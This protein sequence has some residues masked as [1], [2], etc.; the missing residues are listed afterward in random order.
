[1][2]DP[3]PQTS[4][5]ID[6]PSRAAVAA[7]YGAGALVVLGL[8]LALLAI[9]IQVSDSFG[10]MLKLATPWPQFVVQEFTQPSYLRPLL[11]IPLKA[12]HDLSGGHYYAWFRGV[13]VVQVVVLVL[14]FLHLLRP[15]TWRDAAAVPLGLA[16]LVGHHAFTGTVN[17]AF[18]INTFLTVVICCLAAAALALGKERRVNAA[19][20]VVLF[21]Y[22]ALTVESGLLVFVVFVVA[23]ATGARGVPRAGLVALAVALVGYFA[24]RFAVLDVGTPSLSERSSGF[25]FSV[26]DPPELAQ[27]FSDRRLFFYAYNVVAS[28]LSVVFGEPRGGVFRL[29][30]GFRLGAPYPSLLATAVASTAASAL[31]AVFAWHRRSLWRAWQFTHDDRLVLLF[32]VLLPANAAISFP[33]TKD[34]I[35]SPAGAF[36]ALAACVA[37]R[38]LLVPPAGA[39]GHTL[40]LAA[41]LLLSV[42]WSARLLSLHVELRVAQH[43][44]RDEW[45]YVDD[46]IALQRM[47]VSAPR[48]RA[49]RD[50][51]RDDALIER[52]PAGELAW[53]RRRLLY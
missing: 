27:R 29:T 8:A 43:K 16:V 49:L 9:P 6:L 48:A 19:L 1:M 14:L 39:N 25:G 37:A 31:I 3:L 50:T 2:S 21:V 12:V 26:L 40:A 22:A 11:W 17:E 20:A 7:S 30:D 34:V 32:L 36:M 51:L 18:P 10:N 44:V 45:A 41:C 4:G 24:L 28:A 42:A 23:A 53:V 46:W 35:M 13:H 15:R 52:R 38:R 47:D 33:Y 5:E